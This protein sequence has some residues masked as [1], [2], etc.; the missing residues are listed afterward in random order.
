MAPLMAPALLDSALSASFIMKRL[1]RQLHLPCR[2][3]GTKV[4]G[5]GGRAVQSNHG[6]VNFKVLSA[7]RGRRSLLVDAIILSKVTSDMPSCFMPF[8]EKW[9]HLVGLLLADSNFRVSRSIDILLGADIFS[10]AVIQGPV[11]GPPGTPLK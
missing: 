9:K 8:N 7:Y 5:I 11:L 6:T 10:H 3:H 2:H 1:A 4:S